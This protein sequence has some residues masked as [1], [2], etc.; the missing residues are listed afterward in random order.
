M[1]AAAP[2]QP[3][4]AVQL[5]KFDEHT[6]FLVP[7]VDHEREAAEV[8]VAQHAPELPEENLMLDLHLERLNRNSVV[9]LLLRKGHR[10]VNR[11]NILPAEIE[12]GVDRLGFR[13]HRLVPPEELAK[14]LELMPAIKA[15][16]YWEPGGSRYSGSRLRRSEF[17][18]RVGTLVLPWTLGW[19]DGQRKAPELPMHFYLKG[20]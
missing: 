14:Q 11:G 3:P 9:Y 1:A 16:D 13:V 7:N 19:L 17:L 5:P 10:G 4:A 12:S 18:A 2:V 20:A 15:A 8:W 6:L